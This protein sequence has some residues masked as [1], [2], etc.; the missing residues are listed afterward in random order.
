MNFSNATILP[1]ELPTVENVHFNPLEKAYLQVSRISFGI[2]GVIIL[3]AAALLFYFIKK[4]Q[5]PVIIFTAS[6]I[7]IVL[8]IFGWL[9]IG[10]SFKLSGYALRDKDILFKRGWLMQKVRI[11]PLKRIQHVSLQTGPIERKFGLASISIYTAGSDEADFTIRGITMQTA[12]Q[13]KEWI[14]IQLNG[15]PQ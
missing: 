12:E 7:F 9:S 14:S 3:I 4:I 1:Q 13:I 6:A 15:K 8:S 11:V 2:S 5:L 10:L